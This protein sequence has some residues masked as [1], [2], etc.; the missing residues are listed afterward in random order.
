M[1]EVGKLNKRFGATTVLREASFHALPGQ[2]TILTGDNGTGKTTLLRILA[3]LAC[4]SGGTVTIAGCDMTKHRRRAQGQLSFLPQALAFH[5]AMTPEG[6][7]TFY[8]RLRGGQASPAR[9][10]E[11]LEKVELAAD[12]QKPVRH[13]SGGMLQRLGLALLLLPDA[14]VLLLDEP[15]IS[16]D[17]RWRRRLAEILRDETARG[18]TV[19][20]TTHLP[21]EW[22]GEADQHF[23]C[24]DGKVLPAARESIVAARRPESNDD[25]VP[26]PAQPNTTVPRTD[27]SKRPAN[28]S[29]GGVLP[30]FLSSA[31]VFGTRELRT[32]GRNRF[33]HVFAFLAITG[34]AF[35]TRSAPSIEAI[36]FVL[37]QMIL[38]LVPLF[39][40][41]IG[42]SSA[43]GELEEQPFLFS[44]PV[45]RF[46]LVA[47]KASTLV[48]SLSLLLLL[49]FVPSFLFAAD[50]SAIFVLWGMSLLLGAVFI[51]LGLSIG[52]STRERS[53]GIIYAL[54]AWLFLLI[55]FDLLVYLTALL[56]AMQQ[57]PLAW[58]SLLLL[59]PID[60]VRV[61]M[62][63][64]L[65]DIPFSISTD[66]RLVNL[67]LASL[68]PWVFLLCALWIVALLCWSRQRVERRE[69]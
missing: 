65:E 41:L 35:T 45:S 18:K 39:S 57:Q 7:L 15:A 34:G 31:F 51:A 10:A 60:A 44:Q 48:L 69:I 17:P 67:W 3:G 21:N 14:P 28:P 61:A 59:N 6:L 40:I 20:L 46:A 68:V 4:P 24:H 63:F 12:R 64:Q 38:Y 55:G 62:L 5:P 16:L 49:A 8:A 42:L 50:R 30:A 43:H 29:G 2:T 54:L 22:E 25:S 11:L 66:L 27:E 47:G 37:L 23:T 26:P 9:M 32:L 36:P 56:P 53:R 33:L 19:L 58:L 13:L 1:I 52:F